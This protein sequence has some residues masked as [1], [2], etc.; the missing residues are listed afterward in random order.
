MRQLYFFR[1]PLSKKHIAEYRTAGLNLV[2]IYTVL[3]TEFTLNG[4][5]GN[6]SM[7]AN[8]KYGTTVGFAVRIIV[9]LQQC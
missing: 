6:T 7:P 1:G 9:C 5:I 4:D 8:S 2:H 3:R